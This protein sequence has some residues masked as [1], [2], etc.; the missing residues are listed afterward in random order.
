M[1]K[2]EEGKTQTIM[3][4]DPSQLLMQGGETTLSCGNQ[5][6]RKVTVAFKRADATAKGVVGEATGLEF[7]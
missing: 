5:K 1:V 7:N 2:D 3:V 6:S 4:T